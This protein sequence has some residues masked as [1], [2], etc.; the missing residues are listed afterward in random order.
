MG[1]NKALN[2]LYSYFFQLRFCH[3][4]LNYFFLKKDN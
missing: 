4:T 1:K 3:F 2:F